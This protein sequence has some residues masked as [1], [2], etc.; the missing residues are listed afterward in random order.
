MLDLRKFYTLLLISLFYSALSAQI[1]SVGTPFVRNYSRSEYNA[2][3][4]NWDIQQANNGMIYFANNEGLLEFDGAHWNVYTLPNNSIVRSIKNGNNGS[5]MYAG[6]F[7]EIGY[8]KLGKDGGADYT[9]ITALIPEELRDFGEVWNIFIHPDG[10]IFQTY[11]QIMFY[12]NDSVSIINAPSIFH[13]SFMVNGEFYINDME[14]GLL[15]YA[16]GNL[17]TL[18]GVDKLKG[19]EIWGILPYDNKLLIST[20]SDG[21]YLY[22]GNSLEFQNTT[23]SAFLRK[24]Q[25]YSSLMLKD[26]KM[27]FGTIQNGLLICDLS[28]SPLHHI[29]I[30]D[31]IQNNTVLC[32]EEDFLGNLWVGTDHG[33]DYIEINSPLLRISNNYG[34]STGY[35][36]NISQDRIY[37]GTN[38]GLFYGSVSS[39]NELD[40]GSKKLNII[41]ELRGQVW[42]LDEIRG[43][44]FCGHNNGTFIIDGVSAQKI[45]ETPGGWTHLEVPNDSLKVIAGT[46]TGLVLYEKINGKWKFRKQY[47]GFSQS[48]RS[49]AIDKDGT[50]WI[51][52]GYKGVYHIFF[53]KSYNSIVKIDFYD[54]QNSHLPFELF[55]LS[56]IDDRIIF[57]SGS[58]V[59]AYSAKDNDFV[60]DEF[61]KKYFENRH[62]RS[63]KKD[64]EGNIWYFEANDVGVLRITEDGQYSNISLPFKDLH[65]QFVNSFEFVYPYDEENV[66]FGTEYGFEH[67]R[68]KHSKNYNYQF[69]NYIKSMQTFDP[70]SV[71]HVNGSSEES[72]ITLEYSNNGVEFIFSA[73]DFENPDQILFSTFLD[74]YD[75]SWSTWQTRNSREYTNLDEG[76][77]TF[78]VKAKNIYGTITKTKSI[79]FSILPPFQRSLP[80]YSLYLLAFLLFIIF[81]VLTMK[82]RFI[83][84]KLRNQKEQGDLFRKKEEK[85]HRETLEAEKEIIRM[86]NDK[87]REGIKLKDKELANSTI[88]MLHKNEMLITLRDELKKLANCSQDENHK[89]EVKHLVRKINREIDNEKQWMVFETHFESV[90][91]EFLQRIKTTYPK[92]TP[93]ELKLCAYLRMNISSKEISV[94]MNI[95][96]RGVEISRYRLRKKLELKRETNLTDFILSY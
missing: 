90:H 75:K 9:S 82:K 28:G 27:V 78:K 19:K 6:G 86:K 15:R 7:N 62:I 40:I 1:K 58:G 32:L 94:L 31:G 34:I 61:F 12:K 3:N 60:L 76:K 88:E 5:I 54:S 59:F 79:E 77:Y 83:R 33:I 73:N 13:F 42:S 87:L 30:E 96:T 56:L 65:G 45:S 2:G 25:I 84:A 85:L 20:A 16:M 72:R 47:E 35:T 11:S 67:Y 52:H 93:R 71:F 48:S 43:S 24:N 68:P 74:G 46:Y 89:H 4:Q 38:Q 63:V 26:D 92:L 29:N 17:Y 22:N 18:S 95:S 10:I 53:D 39:V 91:E 64:N 36:L 14:K 70:D 57:H 81:I 55:G 23:S 41:E 44:L 69:T 21:T 49:M 80:A 50:L 66:F 8:Y 51:A 37:Y